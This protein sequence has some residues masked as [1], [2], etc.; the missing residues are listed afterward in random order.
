M[1]TSKYLNRT[2]I[3]GWICSAIVLNNVQ[4]KRSKRPGN[5]NYSYWFERPTSDGLAT[6]LI[7]LNSTDAAKVYRGELLL[8]EI[9]D[10][11]QENRNSIPSSR[12]VG[13]C[14]K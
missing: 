2:Y 6:K 12:K 3:G 1:K 10:R 8:D 14:F 7:K 9:A 4:G 5:R 13:Y 11:R